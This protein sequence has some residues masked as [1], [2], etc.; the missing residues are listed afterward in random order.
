LLRYINAE[1]QVSIYTARIDRAAGCPLFKRKK[2]TKNKSGLDG[3]VVTLLIVGKQV[4]G[5]VENTS[6]AFFS[7]KSISIVVYRLTGLGGWIQL[8][9]P[10]SGYYFL[11]LI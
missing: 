5:G 2:A 9:A 3:V 10:P 11:E 7:S 6:L 1:H 8:D 4:Q